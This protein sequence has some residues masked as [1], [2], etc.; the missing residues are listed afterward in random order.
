MARSTSTKEASIVAYFQTAPLAVANTVF[1]I[2]RGTMKGRNTTAPTVTPKKVVK[3]PVKKS[4]AKKDVA[5]APAATVAS[6]APTESI[7]AV[8]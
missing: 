7:S 1:G 5:S 6:P 4:R 2:V 8:A 3:K